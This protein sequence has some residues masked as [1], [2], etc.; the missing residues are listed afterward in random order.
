MDDI[1]LEN[2]GFR[3]ILRLDNYQPGVRMSCKN[4]VLRNGK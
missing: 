4:L 1:A 3:D 2:W